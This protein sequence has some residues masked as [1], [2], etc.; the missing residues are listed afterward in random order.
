MTAWAKTSPLADQLFDEWNAIHS[1]TTHHFGELGE[2]TGD[3]DQA[4]QTV[5]AGRGLA[6]SSGIVLATPLLEWTAAQIGA[7]KITFQPRWARTMSR[8]SETK[9]PKMPIMGGDS[10]ER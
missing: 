1:H 9:M 3:L 2:L 6:E 7:M 5:T 4:L 8:A 10:N